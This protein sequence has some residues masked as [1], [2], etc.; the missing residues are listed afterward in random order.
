MAIT[1]V[2]SKMGALLKLVD[3]VLFAFFIVIAVAAPL[4][5]AQT[6]LS[7]SL[8]PSVLV[9]LKNWYAR[10]YGDYLFT[11]KP[12]FIVGL[13]WL[14]LLFQWPLALANLYGILASKSWFNT[15]C[16]IY[17]VS[18]F[19]SMVKFSSFLLFTC[20]QL[21]FVLDLASWKL[22]FLVFGY[23]GA[24][25][26]DANDVK[27]THWWRLLFKMWE[28]VDWNH[29]LFCLFHLLLASVKL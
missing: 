20:T 7:E 21:S 26:I 25:W 23:F 13:V 17:G 22:S 12:H 6:C 19:T 14:E 3:A 8:F 1:F 28:T 9:D 5:D 2:P 10:E 18:V 29:T 11:E 4:I 27:I 24:V 15:T 16:L